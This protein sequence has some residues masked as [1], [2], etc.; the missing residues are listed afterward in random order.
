MPSKSKNKW[1]YIHKV[2]L[3]PLI[4][5]LDEQGIIDLFKSIES[6]GL[7][8]FFTFLR[9]QGLAQLWLQF[10]LN[11]ESTPKEYEKHIIGFKKDALYIAADQLMQRVVLQ[12]THDAFKNAGVEY[13]VF[14]GAHLRHIIYTD[15][16]HRTVCDIDVM[17]QEPQKLDA[18][19]AL[20][21]NGFCAHHVAKNISVETSL[22]SKNVC[23]DLHWHFLRQGRT[24]INLNDYLFNQR[25]SFDGFQGLNNEAALL[26]ALVHPSIT[27][28]VNGSASSLR[29]L[30][31]IHR[32]MLRD[33][34]NWK[35]LVDTLDKSGVR[36]A[37][38]ASLVWLQILTGEVINESMMEKLKPGPLK[39]WWLRTW[40]TNDLNRKMNSHRWI[41]HIF[42][43]LLLQDRISDAIR[44]VTTLWNTKKSAAQQMKEL[45]SL[46]SD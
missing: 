32:L 45:E 37:A 15:P 39:S 26:V 19:K 25:Q 33:N 7:E 3:R 38:W 10:L 43:N 46:T 14:K 41:I 34:I 44:A 40:M 21:Q 2:A 42:F 13:L 35:S 28:Y 24:R 30:V 29:R 23:I 31:D 20:L 36:S 18:I 16:T 17:V 6:I 9:T 5:P 1:F 12:T 27:E 22:V 4:Y 11:Q 8:R